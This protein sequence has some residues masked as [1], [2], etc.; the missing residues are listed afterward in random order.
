MWKKKK[1]KEKLKYYN[2]VIT[3]PKVKLLMTKFVYSWMTIGSIVV[4]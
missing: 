4:V 1:K 2:V 3:Y